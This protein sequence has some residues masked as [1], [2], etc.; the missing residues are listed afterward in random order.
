MCG[1]VVIA[2]LRQKASIRSVDFPALPRWF[3]KAAS[4]LIIAVIHGFAKVDSARAAGLIMR[5]A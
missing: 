3:R 5:N 4:R 2:P 1:I